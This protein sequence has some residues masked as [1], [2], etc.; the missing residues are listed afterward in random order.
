MSLLALITARGG[1]KG[2]PNKNIKILLDKPLIAWTIEAAKN[3][4]CIDKIIVST[5]NRDIAKIAVDY[6]AEVPFLRPEEISTDESPTIETVLHTIDNIKNFDWL[7]LLQPTSPL[8][9]SNDI[10]GIFKFCRELNSSSAVSICE[11]DKHPIFMYR[12]DNYSNLSPIINE[13]KKINRRQELE[14]IYALNGAL[15]LAK[16]DWL[17]KNKTLVGIN[18]IGFEMPIER[19]IDIDTLEDWKLTEYYLK[20]KQ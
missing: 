2:I 17:K 6:G 1:S 15:Y 8:R 4:K 18:T 16:I 9:T 12:K 3:S 5:D 10:D 19:S 13:K 11:T 20:N 7:I 14:K